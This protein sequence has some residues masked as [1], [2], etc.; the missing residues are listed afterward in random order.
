MSKPK[1]SKSNKQKAGGATKPRSVS[2]KSACPEA[3]DCKK[4]WDEIEK[5]TDV[6]TSN[7]GDT[8][9]IERNRHI[10]AAYAKLYQKN[11]RLKWAGLA[12]IVSRQAGCAMKDAGGRRSQLVGGGDAKVAYE[13]LAKANKTIFEDIYPAMSFYDRY[14]LR[15]MEKCGDTPGHQVPD[16]LKEAIKKIDEGKVRAGADMIANYE[17]KNVVQKKVYADPK[18]KKTFER[19]QDAANSWYSYPASWFGAR[20][21][22]IALSA[23]CGQGTPVPFVGDINDPADRVKYYNSLMKEFDKLSETTGWNAKTQQE[24]VN[25]AN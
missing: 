14:G 12:S 4:A 16:E 15:G 19:N 20:K 18:V 13:A 2:Q 22:E 11:P 25:G 3:L 6:I 23:E 9:P 17:Q 1:L 21:P 7:G 8:D 10:S 5:E 24:I